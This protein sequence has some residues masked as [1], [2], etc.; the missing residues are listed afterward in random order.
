M[1]KTAL[2]SSVLTPKPSAKSF[3]YNKLQ[4]VLC[5]GASAAVSLGG[6]YWVAK[7]LF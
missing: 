7:S 6:L 3:N 2:S 5:I 1:S 4:A